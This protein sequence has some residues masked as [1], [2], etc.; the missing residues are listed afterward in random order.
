[1]VGKKKYPSWVWGWDRKNPSLE[2]THC[3]HSI[4]KP[5]DANRCS[6]GRVFPSHPHTHDRYLYCFTLNVFFVSLFCFFLVVPWVGPQ[7]VSVPWVGLQYVIVPWVGLQCIIVT[8]WWFWLKDLS[9][10]EM[11]GA[12]CFGC[13]QAHRGLPVGFLLIQYSVLFTV[14]SLSLLYLLYI[15]MF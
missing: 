10:D 8:L 6:T 9:I 12:W 11:V 13:C 14:E 4:D 5:R 1:M 7:C 2:I 3:H 15:W